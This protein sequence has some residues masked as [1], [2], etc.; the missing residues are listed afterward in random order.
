[1]IRLENNC[2]YFEDLLKVFITYDDCA[3]FFI[4]PDEELD[5]DDLSLISSA[6]NAAY[7]LPAFG[8]SCGA[9][10]RFLKKHNV[11]TGLYAYYDDE[12]ADA[13]ASAD[14]A[15]D[16]IP[17]ESS[18]LFFIAKD[19][20]ASQSIEKVSQYVKQMRMAPVVPL[21]IFDLYG[22]SMQI[23]RLISGKE[24]FYEIMSDGSVHT[25]NGDID[26]KGLPDPGKLFSGALTPKTAD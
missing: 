26:S 6:S 23:Q 14:S 13:K 11:W 5:E 10:F 1:M 18:F 17:Q 4:L 15:W 22:D 9:N 7:F 16:Y 2:S 3:F 24:Y 21:F 8:D 12:D 19:G 20:V 25:S